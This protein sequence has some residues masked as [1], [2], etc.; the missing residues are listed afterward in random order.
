MSK[1]F[2]ISLL[3]ALYFIP[4]YGQIYTCEQ[5]QADSS[6]KGSK[7][8]II[9]K[10]IQTEPSI[11]EAID[12]IP[13]FCPGYGMIHNLVIEGDRLFFGGYFLFRRKGKPTLNFMW[14]V[15]QISND[16]V[17]VKEVFGKNIKGKYYNENFLLEKGNAIFYIS[18]GSGIEKS[19]KFDLKE[20]QLG[21]IAVHLKEMRQLVRSKPRKSFFRPTDY[22]GAL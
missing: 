18:I 3:L 22:S 19:L 1:I 15:S 5:S 17:V 4:I 12:S 8:W 21:D 9:N 13:Y 14:V 20:Y 16:S 7:Y 10:L 6:S 2:S 11:Y